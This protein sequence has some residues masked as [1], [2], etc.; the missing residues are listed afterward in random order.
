MPRKTREGREFGQE[1]MTQELTRL[2]CMDQ[3]AADTLPYAV[4]FYNPVLKQ[5]V[6]SKYQ[7]YDEANA[8]MR[9]LE[10]DGFSAKLYLEIRPL[11]EEY[12]GNHKP[13]RKRRARGKYDG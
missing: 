13:G 2:K 11:N 12:S 6:I 5:R 4:M 3:L 8:L 1:P 10:L 9:T 7:T